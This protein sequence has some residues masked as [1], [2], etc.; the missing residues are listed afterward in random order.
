MQTSFHKTSASE[1]EATLFWNRKSYRLANIYLNKL[2]PLV[3]TNES[4]KLPAIPGAPIQR[5][6][7][8]VSSSG[9][10]LTGGQISRRVNDFVETSC[11]EIKGRVKGIR[12]RKAVVS[13]H[14]EDDKAP[15]SSKDLAAQMTHNVKTVDKYYHIDEKMKSKVKVGRY[16]ESMLKDDDDETSTPSTTLHPKGKV[17]TTRESE[18]ICNATAPLDGN[19]LLAEILHGL[20]EC[21]EAV[22][23]GLTLQAGRF[24]AQQLRDQFRSLRRGKNDYIF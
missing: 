12:I 15:V 21:P 20:N 19:A 14:R 24:T 23:A 3:A 13:S 11:P 9:K 1:G 18:L 17:F 6:A 10:R 7:F 4:A 8:F 5:S 2:R 16:L 22:E